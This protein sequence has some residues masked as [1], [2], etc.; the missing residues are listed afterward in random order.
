[1]T[2]PATILDFVFQKAGLVMV[3]IRWSQKFMGEG[4][5]GHYKTNCVKML[6]KLHETSLFEFKL[7]VENKL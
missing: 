1:M 3:T 5:K 7:E 2:S 6:G 4:K